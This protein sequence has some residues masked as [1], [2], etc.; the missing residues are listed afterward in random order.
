MLCLPTDIGFI[1][2]FQSLHLLIHIMHTEIIMICL[3]LW[4]IL[5][6]IIVNIRQMQ[7]TTVYCFPAIPTTITNALP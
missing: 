2:R 6:E 1:K 4:Y 3:T 7:Y 5:I